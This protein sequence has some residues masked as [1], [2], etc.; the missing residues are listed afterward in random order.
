MN[1]QQSILNEIIFFSSRMEIREA[2]RES[3]KKHSPKS[4]LIPVPDEESAMNEIR[5]NDRSLLILD[6]EF[7]DKAVI[8]LLEKS[9]KLLKTQS[10]PILMIAK[11]SNQKIIGI[12]CEYSVSRLHTG[13][14]SIK[15]ITDLL[16]ELLEDEILSGPLRSVISNVNRF[17]NLGDW[18]QAS[19]L[20]EKLYKKLPNNPKVAAEYANNLI[21]EGNWQAALEYLRPFENLEPPYLRA[22]QLLG[23]CRMKLGQ[24]KEASESLKKASLIN[25]FNVDRLLLLGQALLFTNEIEE[26]K[27]VFQDARRISSDKRKAIKGESSCLLL[28]GEINQALDLLKEIDSGRETASVFN[29][30]AVMAIRQG[31]LE[32]GMKLYESALHVIKDDSIVRA[33]L[34]FNKGLGFHRQHQLSLAMECFKSAKEL[35]PNFIKAKNNFDLLSKKINNSKASNET[36]L[37]EAS[38]LADDEFRDSRDVAPSFQKGDSESVEG[39]FDDESFDFL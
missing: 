2:L 17:R 5:K 22:L 32:K 8:D 31:H 35:D 34:L 13:D 33:R 24:F 10:R 11:A 19:I 23:R 27:S 14:I 20:L 38:N 4:N 29:S 26:A 18:H 9:T 36:S 28:D 25:P 1:S 30:S 7:G 3:A 39:Y 21:Q 37:Q 16:K 15:K 12:C 6:W